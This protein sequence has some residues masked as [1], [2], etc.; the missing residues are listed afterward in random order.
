MDQSEISRL[1]HRGY[2]LLSTFKRFVHAT[3]GEL[4]IA[5]VTPTVVRSSYSSVTTRNLRRVRTG[6][7]SR[8]RN[9]TR[10]SCRPLGLVRLV[11][12]NQRQNRTSE[13]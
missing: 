2:M 10:K 12:R 11:R 5:V 3:G 1:K 6:A 8:A 9:R 13:T 4:H 7:Y